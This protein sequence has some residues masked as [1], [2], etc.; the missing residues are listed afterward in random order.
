MKASDLF[1]KM[2]AIAG[3]EYIRIADFHVILFPLRKIR[4]N[5]S[6]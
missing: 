5:T 4:T 1:I 3:S 2:M 6:K